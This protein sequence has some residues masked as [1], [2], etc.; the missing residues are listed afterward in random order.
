MSSNHD[1]LSEQIEKEEQG[2][3]DESEKQIYNDMQHIAN[4]QDDR[5]FE[6][7]QLKLMVVLMFMISLFQSFFFLNLAFDEPRSTTE[8][9]HIQK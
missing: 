5:E 2:F 3:K 7:K 1:L 4:R 9:E 8:I 6:V